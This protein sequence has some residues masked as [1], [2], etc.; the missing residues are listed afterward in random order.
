VAISAKFEADFVQFNSAVQGAEVKLRSLEVGTTN[1]GT[2]LSR[3]PAM[4]THMTSALGPFGPMAAAAFSVGAVVNFGREIFAT[5]DTL[6]KLSDRTGIGTEALQRLGSI[7]EESGNSMEQVAD[8]V[9]MMQ[10]RMSTEAAPAIDKLG[11]SMSE[12]KKLS[13][14]QQFIAIGT[15]IA[16]IQDPTER[17]TRAVE[18]FGRAGSEIVPTLRA[19][20]REIADAATVMSTDVTASLDRAGDAWQRFKKN[21]FAQAGSFLGGFVLVNEEFNKQAAHVAKLAT[22]SGTLEDA[23]KA[24]PPVQKAVADGFVKITVPTESALKALNSK[25]DAEL[26]ELNRVRK[27]TEELEEAQKKLTDAFDTFNRTAL[28]RSRDLLRAYTDELVKST[29]VSGQLVLNELEAQIK[30]NNARGLDAF[31]AIKL[32]TTAL[33]TLRMGQDALAKTEQVGISQTAQH[34]VLMDAYTDALL[35]DAIAQDKVRDGASGVNIEVAKAPPLLAAAT[36]AFAQ[37]TGAVSASYQAL[38][39][40][41]MSTQFAYAIGGITQLGYSLGGIMP[42]RR[43]AGGPVSGGSSYWVG[44]KGPELFTPR[45]SGVITPN[46]GGGVIV[47]NVFHIV[48]TESNIARRVAD[49]LK[50]SVMQGRKLGLA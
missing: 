43:A 27:E 49:H 7:A 48:D 20:M 11:L 47:T 10:R 8:A 39:G 35:Q 44:E 41:A 25:L 23:M 46:G 26:F 18:V 4:F 1:V 28:S 17:T 21:T 40:L 6:I 2:A 16:G 37:F 42:Q 38:G 12:L 36:N 15:A 31:G 50:R 9:T 45:A 13:P 30:L 5:A 19:N 33:D 14:D 29:T 3:L 22:L 34:Q 24:I 32:Q